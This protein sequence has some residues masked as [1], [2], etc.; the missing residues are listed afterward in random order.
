MVL[1]PR[2]KYRRLFSVSPI[3][4]ARRAGS[5]M[6]LRILLVDDH[7]IVRLGLRSLLSRYPHFEVVAEAEDGYQAVEMVKLHNPDVVLMDV[8][9]P[10]KN[11]VEATRE[12]KASG[13]TARVIIL[14]SHAED[15]M[16]FDAIGAGAVGYVLKQIGSDD[17]VKALEKVA[18]GEST[19]DPLLT[20]KVFQR[21]RESA[22]RAEDEYFAALTEQ[23]LNILSL[24]TDGLTNRE[25]AERVYLS[26]KT[27]RNY[28]SSILS[29]LD[30]SSRAEAAA[31]AVRHHI[32][33]HVSPGM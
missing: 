33:D 27:V 21:V 3:F 26:E 25:I 11:G 2:Q 18:T 20:Q 15:E 32:Q 14:T 12:I 30:L 4:T 8:R 22:R 1:R 19:L 28:V 7:E 5:F 23:E 10:G 9:M 24:I 17:L 16:L 13:S 29:K 6:R 31:Y